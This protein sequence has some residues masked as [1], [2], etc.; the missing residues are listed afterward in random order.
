[1]ITGLGAIFLPF[2]IF[3][4]RTPLRL[5]Q[6][7][8]I[9]SAFAAAAVLILGSYGVA[10][11][12]LPALLFIG[13]FLLRLALGA[14]YP[15]G[16]GV[17]RVLTPFILVVIG[18]LVSSL[19]MPRFFQDQIFVWPQKLSGFGVL[20]PLSPNAGNY[21]Q[22]MYLI[23]NAGLTVAASLYLV[24]TIGRNMQLLFNTYLYAGLT[25]V[26]ISLW[27]FVSNTV[28]VWFPTS[29]FLSNPGWALL[30]DESIGSVIRLTGPFSEPAALASY[31]CGI[32]GASGWMI[33][34]GD[35]R[36]LTRLA[37]ILGLGVLLL[38]TST[39]GYAAL[40][41]MMAGLALYTFLVG[42]A[43]LKKRVLIGLT[44]AGVVVAIA[45]AA[46][47]AVAPGFAHHAVN[48]FNATVSKQQSSSY[49]DRT[50]T[51][52]DSLKASAA[53]YG[54]GVGWGS[55]RS[56]SLF[57]GL[58]ASVG[59]WGVAGL[60][61]FVARILFHVRIAQ[62]RASNPELKMV[63]HGCT[64]GLVGIL[65]A[66]SISSP[67]LTSPDFYLLL[68]LLIAA[69]GRLRWEAGGA[70]APLP[71]F[72]AFAAPEALAHRTTLPGQ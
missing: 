49:M 9:G 29:F 30:S 35:R 34:N 18:A 66:A 28:H 41:L 54:L 14:T 24:T 38:C 60:L 55:N 23:T 42:P 33:F 2:C 68:G 19:L 65:V 11:G 7:T 67:G 17:L 46:M 53:S 3:L 22:D 45:M 62:R 25:V 69:A 4:W 1:M 5:L 61:W 27:Q 36:L 32:I 39:T 40:L 37:L 63:I 59:V 72:T 21:T 44:A 16:N 26:V 58:A 43:I 71:R 57:P 47:P 51:D 12:L 10:P 50:S 52:L 13:Y 70:H 8:F 31:L 20:T 15:T 56:S 6:L 48:I 64:G